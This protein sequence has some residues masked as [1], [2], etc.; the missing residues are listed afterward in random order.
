MLLDHATML[1]CKLGVLR[2]GRCYH[3][4]LRAMRRSRCTLLRWKQVQQRMLCAPRG[5]HHDGMR[6]HGRIVR[7]LGR[8][9]RQR[10]HVLAS[11]DVRRRS[12]HG[13]LRWSQPIMLHA[14][15][16]HTLLL[17]GR[18]GVRAWDRRWRL[19]LRLPALRRRGTTVL[20]PC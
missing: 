18:N 14:H 13:D 6:R 10:G 17:R 16:Q 2:A 1:G 15:A 5:S 4:G 11:L 12:M 8:H 19:F 20:R 3:G 9:V 7:N